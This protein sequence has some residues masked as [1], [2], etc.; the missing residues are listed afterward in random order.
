MSAPPVWQ[1]I[2][3]LS[4]H[5][6]P[7]QSCCCVQ[8]AAVQVG[9]TQWPPTHACLAVLHFVLQSPQWSGL[10]LSFTHV[11]PQHVSLTTQSGHVLPESL[12][13]SSGP[14]LDDP[15][16]ELEPELEPLLDPELDDPLLLPLLDP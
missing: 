12:P 10:L 2:W 3:L 8:V 9:T 7:Q 13:A 6:A 4:Q 15:L 14:P 16:P 5:T 11:V 1:Q